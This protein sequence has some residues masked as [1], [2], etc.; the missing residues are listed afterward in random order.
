MGVKKSIPKRFSL[1]EAKI[2]CTSCPD[3]LFELGAQSC[4][5]RAVQ[6]L[7]KPDL[8]KNKK[9]EDYRNHYAIAPGKGKN[10]CSVGAGSGSVGAASFSFGL[11]SGEV[12]DSGEFDKSGEDEGE[13]D[14]NEP[15]H[16]S[17]I[18]D[19][20]E[21]VAGTDAQRGHGQNGGDT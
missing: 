11:H 15:V 9:E 14:S 20:G 5:D 17:G 8:K 12:V 13:A 21:R 1:S 6:V 4:S 16:S 3:E 7:S 10:R 18:R 2:G 19:F